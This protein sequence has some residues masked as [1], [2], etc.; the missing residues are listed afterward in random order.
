M[1]RTASHLQKQVSAKMGIICLADGR[2][3]MPS[4]LPAAWHSL[5]Q[6]SHVAAGTGSLAETA[7]AVLPQLLHV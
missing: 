4:P 2:W 5:L 6:P 1:S 3:L 7:M